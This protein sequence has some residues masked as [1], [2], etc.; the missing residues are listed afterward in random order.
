MYGTEE[1]NDPF[2]P[3]LPS[4]MVQEGYQLT[5]DQIQP[6]PVPKSASSGQSTVTTAMP[7]CGASEL[8]H[9]APIMGQSLNATTPL[10][11]GISTS[12]RQQ[13][14][15]HNMLAGS[16]VFPPGNLQALQ[17]PSGYLFRPQ[18]ETAAHLN[19]M[20]Q[21]HH[22]QGQKAMPLI[23]NN[24]LGTTNLQ[25]GNQGL[26]NPSNLHFHLQ[27][28]QR[29]QL[30]QQSIMQRKMMAGGLGPGIGLGNMGTMHQGG[31]PSGVGSTANLSPM[32]H[33][34]G[35]GAMGGS[36]SAP[37]GGQVP[38]FNSLGQITNLN[39]ASGFGSL[40]QHTRVGS[41]PHAQAAALAAKMKL[42]QSHGRAMMTG[43]PIRNPV[44][45][46]GRMAGNMVMPGGSMS[47]QTIGRSI[48]SQLQCASMASMGPPKVPIM[49]FYMNNQQQ[50]QIQQQQVQKPQ[51]M[52]S[53]LQQQQLQMCAPLQQQLGSPLQQQQIGSPLQ[54][55]Q[56]QICAQLQQQMGS[57]LQQPQHQ[58]GSPLQQP[59]HQ[60]GS[61]LQQLQQQ[62]I[63]SP[64]QQPQIS[65]LPELVG[66]PLSHVSPQ[67]MNQQTPMSPQ[68][69]SGAM[70]QQQMI[71]GSVGMGPNSPQLSSQT[72]GSVASISS[73]PMELQGVSKGASVGTD[74]V[75]GE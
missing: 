9:S 2:A 22:P 33:V 54:Q 72:L 8:P 19:S 24:L 21:Q 68:I 41:L 42:A 14:S 71:A 35:L 4:T 13:L 3:L 75:G 69:S 58:M 62:Q 48:M 74:L 30:Q 61:P 40:N 59:Q 37:M 51:Q 16:H 43:G 45:G 29:H 57:P 47:S 11:S 67:Q 46:L 44:D 60:M 25:M 64:L 50:Q 56:Q 49:N 52:G 10:N 15:P 18:P 70:P 39:Q 6:T 73:S 34:V 17:L 27:Q 36:M 63:G 26:N 65:S 7:G 20:Q 12:N 55:Q 28:R 66:S 32:S 1:E 31:G 23:C 38:G 5:D 53:S